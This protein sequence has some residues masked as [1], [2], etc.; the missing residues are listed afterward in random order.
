MAILVYLL[1]AK[2]SLPLPLPQRWYSNFNHFCTISHVLPLHHPHQW[3][4]ADSKGAPL[5][6][7]ASALNSF[8]AGPTAALPVDAGAAPRRVCAQ[9][10]IAHDHAH[11]V[12]IGACDLMLCPPFNTRT[13]HYAG[14]ADA[15][16]EPED[17]KRMRSWFV[18]RCEHFDIILRP[19]P[20]PS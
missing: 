9:E 10:L 13:E 17:S 1:G 11:R 2:L 4:Q 7:R 12:L 14:G 19:F 5:Q 20:L 8:E 3:V 16:E 15:S 6:R 18:I